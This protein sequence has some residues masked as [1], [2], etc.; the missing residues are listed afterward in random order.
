M[1]G[2]SVE[3]VDNSTLLRSFQIETT[4]HQNVL[5]A[6]VTVQCFTRPL[7]SLFKVDTQENTLVLTILH[8]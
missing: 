7:Q 2:G 6:S 1:D 8:N 5:I 4:Q 3:V